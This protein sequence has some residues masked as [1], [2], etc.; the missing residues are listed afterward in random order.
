MAKDQVT[1]ESWWEDEAFVSH[2]SE[3]EGIDLN[4]NSFAAAGSDYY[5]EEAELYY[6]N[7]PQGFAFF[8]RAVKVKGGDHYY[9]S[10]N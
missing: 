8:H 2:V 9:A 10:A 5:F 7:P 4:K 3:L 1:R 6:R